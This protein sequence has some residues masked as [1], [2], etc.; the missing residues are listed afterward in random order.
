M[1]FREFVVEL[2]SERNVQDHM[3]EPP[4]S[5]VETWLEW[6]AEQLGTPVW[7]LDLKAIPGVKDP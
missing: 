5:N 3:M 6:Q 4:V 7:W 2:S 1:I